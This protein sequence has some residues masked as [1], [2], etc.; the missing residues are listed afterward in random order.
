MTSPV[1]GAVQ[2]ASKNSPRRHEDHE[3]NGNALNVLAW[4]VAFYATKQAANA[5]RAERMP[6]S[7]FVLFVSSW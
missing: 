2:S 5:L 4:V 6:I 3:E 1:C 7:C